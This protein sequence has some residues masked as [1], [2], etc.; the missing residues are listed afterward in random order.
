MAPISNAERLARAVLLFFRGG[1]WTRL[2]D[3]QWA[4]LTGSE[5]ASSRALCDLAR[6][7]RSEEERKTGDSHGGYSG[8]HSDT[9]QSA[10]T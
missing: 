10:H 4:A 7:V 6:M 9:G 2:D 1:R 8:G 3:E 5:T